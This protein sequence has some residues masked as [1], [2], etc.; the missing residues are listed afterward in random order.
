[1]YNL[2]TNFDKMLDIYNQLG[3]ESTN[4]QGNIS[5]RGVVPRFSDLKVVALLMAIYV[6]KIT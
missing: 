1:M 2:K 3:E 4:E 6:L 5:R